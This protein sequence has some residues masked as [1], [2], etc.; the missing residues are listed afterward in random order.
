[1]DDETRAL[2]D[3]GPALRG[4]NSYTVGNT[5][6][7]DNQTS[8]ASFRIFLDTRDWDNALGMNTPGQ[9][10]DPESP[11]YRNLFDLWADDRVFAAFY[12]REKIEGVT[13]ERVEL[14]PGG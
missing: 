12:S 3:V 10:G 4:G 2:L 7:G 6:G 14:R 1:V 5:G 13:E 11:F 8:G 9:G